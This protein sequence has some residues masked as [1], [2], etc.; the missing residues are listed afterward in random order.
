MTRFVVKEGSR[1]PKKREKLSV[2]D[3]YLTGCLLAKDVYK[4]KEVVASDKWSN[5]GVGWNRYYELFD[6]RGATV[7]IHVIVEY[8]FMPVTLMPSNFVRL[9]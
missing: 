3:G 1:Y 5:D 4:N 7:V 2:K 8:C 9:M 6:E